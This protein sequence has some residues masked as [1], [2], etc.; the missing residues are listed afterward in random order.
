[1]VNNFLFYDNGLYIGSNCLATN[2][3]NIIQNTYIIT[4]DC[5]YTYSDLK[6][7]LPILKNLHSIKC[8]KKYENT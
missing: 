4:N 8:I 6:C 7:K 3:N 5:I 2:D 1:M